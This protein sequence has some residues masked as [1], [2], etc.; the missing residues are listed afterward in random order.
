[1]TVGSPTVI[2]SL[3]NGKA[4]LQDADGGGL[5]QI[6]RLVVNLLNKQSRTANKGYY[7]RLRVEKGANNSL[8]YEIEH[9]MKCYTGPPIG[10]LSWYD[11]SNGQLTRSLDLG[12]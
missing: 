7:S 3:Y 2:G 10:R 11:L 1:V 6:C 9:V 12:I 4:R 8:P 5:L